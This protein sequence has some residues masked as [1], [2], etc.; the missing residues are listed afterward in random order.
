MSRHDDAILKTNGFLAF[1]YL[2]DAVHVRDEAID[3]DLQ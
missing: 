2:D 3:P 1:P